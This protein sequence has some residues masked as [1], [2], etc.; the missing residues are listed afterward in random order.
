M[1]PYMPRDQ[2][3]QVLQKDQHIINSIFPSSQIAL[4]LLKE[5]SSRK[6]YHPL[7]IQVLTN[8]GQHKSSVYFEQPLVF[9]ISNR[10]SPLLFELSLDPKSSIHLLHPNTKEIDIFLHIMPRTVPSQYLLDNY[11]Y[12]QTPLEVT[13]YS[14]FS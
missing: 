10:V 14:N 6:S 12:K 1:Q 5:L 7:Q 13:T 11:Y 2:S 3:D 4:P 8:D 9:H